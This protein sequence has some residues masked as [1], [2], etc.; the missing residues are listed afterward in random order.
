MPIQDQQRIYDGVDSWASGMDGGKRGNLIAPDAYQEGENVVCRDGTIST[1]PRFRTLDPANLNNIWYDANG[2]YSTTPGTGTSTILA[3]LSGLYQGSLYYDPPNDEAAIMTM[4]GG[5]LFKLVPRPRFVEI[6]EIVLPRQNRGNIPIAYL[7]QADRFLLVQDGESSCIIYDGVTARRAG[8]DEIPVGEIMVYGMGR[9]VLI[10]KNRKD[11]LFGDLYGSHTGEPGDS[12]LKFT[13][14]TF[15]SEGGAASIPFNIGHI[16]GAAFMPQQDTTTGQGQLL[17]FA[18]KGMAT[19]F[20]SLPREQWKQSQFQALA[21]IDIG[22][23]GHRAIIPVNGD[24]WFR[25]Q[26]GWR[27]YRQAHAEA[28]GWFQLPLST[29]VGK[30]TLADT[31]NY[32]PYASGVRFK[33]RL[34]LT[35]TPIPNNGRPY[36]NGL[37]SLDFAVL[38][39]FGQ[40]KKPSWDGHWSGIRATELIEGNFNGVRRAFA[41]GLDEFGNNVLHELVEDAV[42]DTN[43]PV[44]SYVIPRTFNFSAPFNESK[45]SD[46]DIWQENVKT[47]TYMSISFRPDRY[48]KFV[49]W[50]PTQQIPVAMP[51]HNADTIVGLPTVAPGF[52]PRLGIGT[53]LVDS[54]LLSTNRDLKRGYEVDMKIGWTGNMSIKQARFHDRTQLERHTSNQ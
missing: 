4:I 49:P 54:D 41:F 34:I 39:S 42:E 52:T 25:S 31:Q 26:D 46:F 28:R 12:V 7:A 50:N 44:Q 27:A 13:E 47:N 21:L 11:I 17:V 3:F 1:R 6:T 19:F 29:E 45:I 48:P 23:M 14:T 30:W 22:G 18:E 20:L 35:S 53:P 8:K 16:R 38:S 10:G 9:V 36:H 43:G 51:I 15:L 40:A 37:L 5:R 33:N 2:D 32:L 24:V